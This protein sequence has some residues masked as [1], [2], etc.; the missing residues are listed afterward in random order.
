MQG[1]FSYQNPTKLYFG[2]DAL[3]YLGGG[4]T[5]PVR[6]HGSAMLWWKQCQA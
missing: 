3:K 1:N 2:E 4:R 6:S 5:A